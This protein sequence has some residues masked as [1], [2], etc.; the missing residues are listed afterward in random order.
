MKRIGIVGGLGP[1]ATLYYYRTLV[2]LWYEDKR[3]REDYPEIIVY[4]V[5]LQECLK[6]MELSMWTELGDRMI[7]AVGSLQKA[8]ADFGIIAANTPHKV[9]S[10]IRAKSP[11]PLLSIVE[12][13]C[14]AVARRGLR[15]VGLLGTMVTMSSN[16]YEDAFNK[17]NI[18]IVVPNEDDQAYIHDRILNQLGL[19]IMLD[20]TRQ[21]FLRITQRMIDEEGIEGLILGCTEIP[22]LLTKEEL[23]IP[24]FDTA[25][26]HC[27]GALRY[28]LSE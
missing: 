17:S 23:S 20:E 25:K 10:D 14:A 6:L 28:C 18:S 24:F 11:I 12:E 15:K 4:S 3:L 21:G 7:A 19:G 27:E 13:T 1:E 8:G 26:I 9:F 5:N 22:L 2:D 16:F